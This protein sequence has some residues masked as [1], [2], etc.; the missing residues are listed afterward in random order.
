[1]PDDDAT[2]GDGTDQVVDPEELVP[3]ELLI[4]GEPVEVDDE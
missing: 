3:G 1:M 2:S 4:D